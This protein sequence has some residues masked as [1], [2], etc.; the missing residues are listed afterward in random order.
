MA[1]LALVLV[2]SQNQSQV[3]SVAK[4]RLK[5]T[6]KVQRSGVVCWFSLNMLN[7]QARHFFSNEYVETKACYDFRVPFPGEANRSKL[8]HRPPRRT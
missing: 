5:K 4:R 3:G 7:L 2:E 1:P 6:D 8:T